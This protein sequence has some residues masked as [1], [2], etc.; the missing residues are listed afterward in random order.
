VEATQPE[1][2]QQVLD[3][4]RDL[5][6]RQSVDD[7]ALFQRAR[8]I[9]EAVAKTEAIDGFRFWSVRGLERKLSRPP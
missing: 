2:V 6:A 9:L 4:A 8:K 7:D 1:H 5:L 3:D